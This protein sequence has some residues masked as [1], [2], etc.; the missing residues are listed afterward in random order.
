MVCSGTIEDL[1]ELK[2]EGGF[3]G[4]TYWFVLQEL[5]CSCGFVSH[6]CRTDSAAALRLEIGGF[7]KQVVEPVNC[8]QFRAGK[9]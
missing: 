1:A 9:S 6:V 7:R 5:E 4:K 8:L 2:I 3:L